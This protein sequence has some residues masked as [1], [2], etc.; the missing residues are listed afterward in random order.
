M[1]MTNLTKEDHA[2]NW[3][4]RVA[5]RIKCPPCAGKRRPDRLADHVAQ[6]P[7]ICPECK[8]IWVYRI[9]IEEAVKDRIPM[10]HYS[11]NQLDGI[12]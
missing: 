10:W 1:R 11:K 4:R 7:C 5:R 12:L 3:L 8:K 2:R 6:T 9:R